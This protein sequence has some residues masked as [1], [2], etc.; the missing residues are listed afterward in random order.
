MYDDAMQSGLVEQTLRTWRDGERLLE[1]LAPLSADH[2]TMRLL[3]VE[4]RESYQML[5]SR[6]DVSHQ[7]L[8]E[9]AKQLAVARNTI[10]NVRSK[11]ASDS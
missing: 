4:L 10:E 9:C 3:L 6:S 8:D 11:L 2:Q 5:T 1:E 7:Q